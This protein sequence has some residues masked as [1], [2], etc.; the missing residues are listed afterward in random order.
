MTKPRYDEQENVSRHA[1]V[2]KEDC[3]KMQRKH[4]WQ[5][6]DIEKLPPTKNQLFKVDCV[7]SGH[8]EFPKPANET[9]SDWED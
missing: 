1:A 9:K 6:V 7:F 2:S 5:L 3:E 4:G 8:T